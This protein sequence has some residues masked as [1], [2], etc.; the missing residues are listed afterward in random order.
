MTA[1]LPDH[2]ALGTMHGK[3]AVIAP[4]FAALGVTVVLAEVETDSFGT[5]S[6]D[7]PRAGSMIE[8]AR[9]KAQAAIAAT[10][11]PV[12]LASEG[13]YG[14]HPHF[15]FLPF[16]QELLLWL[17][18]RTGQEVVEMTTDIQP[19]YD[20]ETVADLAAAEAFLTRIG[21]PETAVIV[22]PAATVPPLAKGVRDRTAL[23]TLLDDAFRFGGSAHLQADM[24]AHMNPRRMSVIAGL[25]QRLAKR[26]AVPCPTCAAPGF[27][28]LRSLPGL[29]C[30]EC[31]TETGLIAA[32]IHGCTA[33][34]VERSLPRE[35]LAD[36]GHCP[37]CNP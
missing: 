15:A 23:F 28:R 32:E 1:P 2:V 19:S 3:E 34:G 35:G 30:R 24:R 33:C 12:G 9:A 20:Q 13:A 16:G 4:P 21:F 5:F 18:I 6:G 36:P 26:L 7:V 22:Q 27:G 31:G 11:L 8:A 37:S 29:P 14:P 10:G 25:A 17:D